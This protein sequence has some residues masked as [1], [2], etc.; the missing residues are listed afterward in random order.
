MVMGQGEDNHGGA[1]KVE[2]INSNA[3]MGGGRE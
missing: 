1:K 3:M 2:R